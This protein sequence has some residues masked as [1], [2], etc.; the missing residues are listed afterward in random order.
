MCSHWQA[1]SVASLRTRASPSMRPACLASTSGLWRVPAAAAARSSS[2]GC[3]DPRKSRNRL[4]RYRSTTGGAV[5]IQAGCAHQR[6]L[7]DEVEIL[8]ESVQPGLLRIVEHQPREMIVLS[9]EQGERE[10]LVDRHDLVEAEGSRKQAAKRI[11]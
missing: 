6:T 11:Q 4:A 1:N 8:P 3:D 10:D 9:I 5:E 2:A 7:A